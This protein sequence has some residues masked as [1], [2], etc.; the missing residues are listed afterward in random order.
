G[1][2]SLV[3][4]EP[5]AERNYNSWYD[6]DHYYSGVLSLPWTLGGARWIATRELRA[7]RYPADSSVTDDLDRGAFLNTY[8]AAAGR[9]DEFVYA[10]GIAYDRLHRQHRMNQ[11]GERSQVYTGMQEFVGSVR[12]DGLV[13]LP[14][15]AFTYPYRWSAL[16]VIEA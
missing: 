11:D 12:R 2:I 13:P 7:L 8:L 1:L 5:G 3:H 15:H 16:E 4:V 10:A 14:I 9:F 6:D